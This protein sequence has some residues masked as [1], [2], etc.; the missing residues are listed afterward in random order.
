[1]KDTYIRG[2]MNG[3]KEGKRE[4]LIELQKEN[5]NADLPSNETLKKIFNLLFKCIE[6]DGTSVY[7]NQYDH[8]ADYI[9]LNW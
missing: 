6:N 9:T 8:Y 2:Y 7:M 4:A 3:F 5:K 1:M